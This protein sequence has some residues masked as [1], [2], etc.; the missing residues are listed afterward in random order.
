MTIGGDSPRRLLSLVLL[1]LAVA[2]VAL[3]T[4]ALAGKPPK[5]GT[6]SASSGFT[7]IATHPQAVAQPTAEGKTI[8]ALKQWNGKLYS[9]YGDYGANT[10]PIAVNPF[11][12]SSFAASPELG[13]ADT[14]A[15]LGYRSIGGKLY[16]PSIDP[17]VSSDFAVG[18]AGSTGSSW[19]NPAPIHTSHAFDMA[20][21]TGSDL[22][23]VGSSGSDAVAWRSLDGGATWAEMLRLP[24]ASGASGDF[25]RFYGVGVHGGKLYLQASDYY[26][27]IQPTSKVFDGSRWTDGPSLNAPLGHSEAFAGKLLFHGNF[28]PGTNGPL[29]AFDGSTVTTT[30]QSSIFDYA[31]DNGTVYALTTDRKVLASQDLATWTQV[32]S[33]P[34]VARSIGVMGGKVY[35]GGTDSG[36]YRN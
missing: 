7:K 25:A 11:D 21:L 32:G 3:P 36:I 5:R 20:T 8:S 6:T 4:T 28:H 29:K 12:G 27:Y 2:V 10:G 34:S 1:G 33:A 35:L 30:L 22:W 18:S 23:L 17:R 26:S 19:M 16:A 15:I 9:G 24:P 13:A 31:V 14:E